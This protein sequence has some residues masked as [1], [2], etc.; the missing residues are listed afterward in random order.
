MTDREEG[1]ARV[2]KGACYAH[3]NVAGVTF[4]Q[5][6]NCDDEVETPKSERALR[7][8]VEAINTA[9]A[10]EKRE[11]VKEEREFAKHV[12]LA[13]E[14]LI[15]ALRTND[16]TLHARAIDIG[17]RCLALESDRESFDEATR[18]RAEEKKGKGVGDGL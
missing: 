14:N 18:L 6:E 9:F 3:I 13:V 15:A 12:R 8:K 1:V 17:K 5:C 4:G 7:W 2:V 11:A 10:K 16:P